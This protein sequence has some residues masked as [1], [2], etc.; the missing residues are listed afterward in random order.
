M[1]F[2]E[3]SAIV[4]GVEGVLGRSDPTWERVWGV[5]G[6]GE[7]LGSVQKMRVFKKVG[8]TSPE[9]PDESRGLWE[10]RTKEEVVQQQSIAF[11]LG[12]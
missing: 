6:R 8:T 9:H 3:M 5:P 12:V 7:V 2:R 4:P 10:T 11:F 1:S